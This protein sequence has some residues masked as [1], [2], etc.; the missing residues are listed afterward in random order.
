MSRAVL[1]WRHYSQKNF[2]P[3]C[4]WILLRL[5]TKTKLNDNDDDL[6]SSVLKAWRIWGNEPKV[7]TVISDPAHPGF[8][9]LHK[10]GL[11]IVFT[12]WQTHWKSRPIGIDSEPALAAMALIE[13][14]KLSIEDKKDIAEYDEEDRR[15]LATE[16]FRNARDYKAK[17]AKANRKW[18]RKHT[19]VHEAMLTFVGAF[20]EGVENLPEA[21]CRMLADCPHRICDPRVGLSAE[22]RWEHNFGVGL[23]SP[24]DYVHKAA[25]VVLNLTDYDDSTEAELELLAIEDSMT[26]GSFI[27]LERDS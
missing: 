25:K 24:H 15:A 11:D 8:Y 16:I 2:K 13:K 20:D 19:D 9:W 3:V 18:R 7:C 10:G 4:Y 21:A 1:R 27:R 12:R 6:Q 17:E 14:R 26:W 23:H 22:E 5:R